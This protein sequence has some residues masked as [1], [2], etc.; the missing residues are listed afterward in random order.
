MRDAW[1]DLPMNPSIRRFALRAPRTT[2]AIA[3]FILLVGLV[4]QWA[5]PPIGP[6]S[7]WLALQATAYTPRRNVDGN[8]GDWLVNKPYLG[9][10][11]TLASNGT[12][13]EWVW[14]A[15]LFDQR[16]NPGGW[17]ENMNNWDIELV[18][19]I[20]D[21]QYLFFLV[22]VDQGS[23]AWWDWIFQFNIA[24]DT[25]I[26]VNPA[27][28]TTGENWFGDDA[29]TSLH[30]AIQRSELNISADKNG[31]WVY[32]TGSGF[33]YNAPNSSTAFNIGAGTMEIGIKWAD[34]G[35]TSVPPRIR[36]TMASAKRNCDDPNTCNKT[37]DM[38]GGT[39]DM[40]DA[41]TYGVYNTTEIWRDE[42]SDGNV[43][44]FLDIAFTSTGNASNPTLP[45]APQNLRV[46][47]KAHRVWL[48]SGDT[49]YTNNPLL[50]WNPVPPDGDVGDS[51]SGYYIQ[52]C[53]SPVVN[54]NGFFHDAFGAVV[55]WNTS[56]AGPVNRVTYANNY[57][58][59]TWWGASDSSTGVP[60]SDGHGVP[61][62]VPGQT[63]YIRVWARD[64]RGMLGAPSQTYVLPVDFPTWHDPYAFT[65]DGTTYRGNR[66][67]K[68]NAYVNFTVG[69][70][71]L[72]PGDPQ[73]NLYVNPGTGQ[74]AWNEIL[75]MV[76]HIRVARAG[77]F[78]Y[79]WVTQAPRIILGDEWKD[80]HGN[81][82]WYMPSVP[83]PTLGSKD[84]PDTF[85]FWR[86]SGIIDISKTWVYKH[87]AVNLGGA[88]GGATYN[89][90]AQ[91]GDIVEYFFEVN[92]PFEAP[93]GNYIQSQGER[94]FLFA[95]DTQGIT[96]YRH[97]TYTEARNRPFRFVVQ[98]RDLSAV[99]HNPLSNEAPFAAGGATYSMRS[100]VWPDTSPQ[101]VR[102]YVGAIG[103]TGLAWQ[104]V[105][106]SAPSTTWNTANFNGA[107][108]LVDTAN[109]RSYANHNFNYTGGQIEYYF[110][111]TDNQLYIFA[112][113]ITDNP[114][115][116]YKNSLGTDGRETVSF[117][118]PFA[119]RVRVT[120]TAS[121][122][123]D[124]HTMMAVMSFRAP[125]FDAMN[126]NALGVNSILDLRNGTVAITGNVFTN[127]FPP[128]H[129]S[130]SDTPGAVEPRR[131]FGRSQ[132]AIVAGLTNVIN[133]VRQ[134]FFGPI[135]PFNYGVSDS[136][137][138]NTGSD[139]YQNVPILT[140]REVFS[141]AVERREPA[142]TTFS[143]AKL[144]EGVVY[145]PGNATISSM[146]ITAGALIA[147]SGI[148]IPAGAI[149]NATRLDLC[150][151]NGDIRIAGRLDI[152]TGVL[153]SNRAVNVETGA[154]LT[155]NRLGSVVAQNVRVDSAATFTVIHPP[156]VG[157]TAT[158]E[159]VL[160]RATRWVIAS[161][162][163]MR[164]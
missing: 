134:A 41:V 78:T 87:N 161:L 91:P 5:M 2:I 60:N 3:F 20:A 69:A 10:T 132:E 11:A 159:S 12:D 113:G 21:T 44:V 88:G 99:W 76:M 26:S 39:S 139:A 7:G 146:A 13:T 43:A 124:S 29:Q 14:R 24:M 95:H 92:N 66:D 65:P 80:A 40:I 93:G 32:R 18:R 97:G 70:F 164:R 50:V 129:M 77:H 125:R 136:S 94:R 114:N 107:T 117:S 52:V 17:V 150:A 42:L 36:L 57:F 116:V 102:L 152:E 67:P 23:A 110:K 104:M 84:P 147:E 54:A 115:T 112:N 98:R 47:D 156:T 145:V 62:L 58:P 143:P 151:L 96:G 135:F 128:T 38:G 81:I 101:T 89:L 157:Y 49:S 131:L 154:R 142:G 140:Y 55:G 130:R 153:F 51:I 46:Y 141:D 1:R 68:E 144:L 56:G 73:D 15:K 19:V 160:S 48:Q 109:H 75:N 133:G 85:T 103:A 158:K 27:G 31:V 106:R 8:A 111:T 90:H 45:A 6:I 22:E 155:M 16:Q 37:A 4:P 74:F 138:W 61:I 63:Y 108:V 35:F 9:N 126:E 105:W 149:I 118:F 163:E 127:A 123:K 53:T 28:G 122:G 162:R 79:D 120:S 34:L 83:H 71:D 121:I 25:Q 119:S 72:P 148:V 82:A 100:P 33:W 137:A 64:R 30:Q 86:T 59:Q